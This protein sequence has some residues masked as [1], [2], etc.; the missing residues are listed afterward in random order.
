MEISEYCQIV[1]RGDQLADKLIAPAEFTDQN[2]G[3]GIAVPQAPG[4]PRALAFPESSA[5]PV[6]ARFPGPAALERDHERGR[7]LHFFANHELLAL[8]LMALTLLRFPDAPS[9]F[10]R[11]TVT[12]ML[13]EQKHMRL[14]LVRMAE[15]GVEF[16]EIEVSPFFWRCLADVPGLTHFVAGRKQGH[17]QAA[18]HS[19]AGIA[20]ARHQPQL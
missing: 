20:Q 18:A 14:Y 9:A 16:G 8:E 11:R 19:D 12:T 13:E 17:A 4:R 7:A 1:L 5:A 6:R 15:L 10:R 3:T 2:P